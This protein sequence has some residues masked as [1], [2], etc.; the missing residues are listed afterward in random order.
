MTE[1]VK[2]QTRINTLNIFR[3]KGITSGI[4][5]RVKLDHAQQIETFRKN[6]LPYRLPHVI[7][8]PN[9]LTQVILQSYIVLMQLSRCGSL[10]SLNYVHIWYM[11]YAIHCSALRTSATILC[12]WVTARTRCFRHDVFFWCYLCW[13]WTSLL[14][15]FCNA[16]LVV[17]HL[18]LVS[19]LRL[20]PTNP[21]ETLKE[22]VYFDSVEW[23][24]FFSWWTWQGLKPMFKEKTSF[25]NDLQFLKSFQPFQRTSILFGIDISDIGHLFWHFKRL[26][27]W[28]WFELLFYFPVS[29]RGNCLKPPQ[30]FASLVFQFHSMRFEFSLP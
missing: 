27:L 30:L 12:L 24:F 9:S 29:K 4:Q 7:S 19:G 8:R 21:S 17:G 25:W 1:R 28:P 14:K 11:I 13:D 26:A 18:K 16:G 2:I 6:T 3:I 20:T 10:F 22:P 15:Q 23:P 5:N